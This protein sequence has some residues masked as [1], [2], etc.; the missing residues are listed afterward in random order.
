MEKNYRGDEDSVVVDEILS[1]LQNKRTALKTIRI[2]I[3]TIVAQTSLMGLLIATSKYHE[4]FQVMHWMISL[5]ALNVIMLGFA[6]YLIAGSLMHILR[7]DKKILK[8]KRKH[9]E[10]AYPENMVKTT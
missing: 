9:R 4:I 3:A 1:L 8:L 10:F 6:I 5:V 2:G 7:L